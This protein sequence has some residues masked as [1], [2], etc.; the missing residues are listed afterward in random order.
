MI[1]SIGITWEYPP[2]VAVPFEPK[3]GPKEGSRKATQVLCP[4]KLR[5]SLRPM[6]VVVFPS[7]ADVGFIDVTNINFPQLLFLIFSHTELKTLAL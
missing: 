3:H 7:P 4:I 2:P 5:A 1:S 6:L